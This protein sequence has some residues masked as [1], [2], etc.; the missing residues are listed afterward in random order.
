MG[1]EN[2]IQFEKCTEHYAI[3]DKNAESRLFIKRGGET[4]EAFGFGD[5]RN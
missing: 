5:S 4:N 1:V 2:E 3:V